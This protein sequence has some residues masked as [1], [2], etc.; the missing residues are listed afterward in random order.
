MAAFEPYGL[1]IVNIDDPASPMIVASLQLNQDGE[2]LMLS[3]NY[4]YIIGADGI[5][6]VD[7][8]EPNSPFLVSTADNSNL[9]SVYSWGVSEP[10]IYAITYEVI[11][12]RCFLLTWT[13]S[14]ISNSDFK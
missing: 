9:L 3:G 1:N 11:E 7:V 10:Y 2:R 12:C 4:L 14:E 6:T 13:S 5:K 8:S